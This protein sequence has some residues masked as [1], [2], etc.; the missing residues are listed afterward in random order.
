[1]SKK[2]T[3]ILGHPSKDS[4]CGAIMQGYVEGAREAGAEVREVYLGDLKF[5]PILWKG[6]SATQEL[7]EDLKKTQE[8][9]RWAEH[10]VFVYPTWWGAMPAIMKGFVDRIFL[11]G[12]G[13]KFHKG[14]A[15]PDRLLSNKS[16]RLIVTMDNKKCMKER[17]LGSPSVVALKNIVLE[18]CGVNPVDVTIVSSLRKFDDEKKKEFL[19]EVKE[20]GRKFL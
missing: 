10:L 20:M 6:Y 4:F 14:Q 11:P 15:C 16:A 7:E 9:M 5:D 13:F 19:L 8:D 17:L 2:I 1:M 3:V 12:F 18:F